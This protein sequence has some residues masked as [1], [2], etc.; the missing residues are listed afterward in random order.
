MPVVVD[1]SPA[2]GIAA[3]GGIP[4][5]PAVVD[6]SPGIGSGFGSSEGMALGMGGAGVF[7]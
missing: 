7:G 2:I 4:A 3:G 1:G 5:I 6:G